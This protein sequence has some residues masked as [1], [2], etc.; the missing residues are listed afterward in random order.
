MYNMSQVKAQAYSEN[1]QSTTLN[2]LRYK[3]SQH[4]LSLLL[5]THGATAVSATRLTPSSRDDEPL[6]E[7]SIEGTT[8]QRN[9][10]VQRHDHQPRS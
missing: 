1:L 10:I 9:R 5:T 8:K 7:G 3:S 6:A 4:S 2:S